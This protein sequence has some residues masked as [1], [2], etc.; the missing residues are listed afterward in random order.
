MK[1]DITLKEVLLEVQQELKEEIGEVYSLEEINT[2]VESQF[3]ASNLAFKK[4]VNIRLPRFGTFIR[5]YGYM[6]SKGA[7]ALKEAKHTMT[8]KKYEDAVREHKIIHKERRKKLLASLPVLTVKDLSKIPNKVEVAN[9][10]DK[11]L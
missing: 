8:A 10:Y 9:R 2:V 7:K 3:I 4:G 5:K 11:L 1:L 6:F